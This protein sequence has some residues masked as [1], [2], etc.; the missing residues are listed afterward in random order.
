MVAEEMQYYLDQAVENDWTDQINCWGNPGPWTD[1]DE[2]DPPTEMEAEILCLG[3]P[4]KK[5][6]REYGDVMKPGIGVFG[7]KTWIAKQSIYGPGSTW[8]DTHSEIIS[9]AAA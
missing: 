7:G 1:W 3:C 6:C 8:F 5:L 2:N 9:K 4:L